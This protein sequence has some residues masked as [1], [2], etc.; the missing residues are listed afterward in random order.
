V[1]DRWREEAL[2][3]IFARFDVRGAELSTAHPQPNE[4]AW[5][6]GHAA[7]RR[8]RDVR[9]VGA[10]GLEPA[11]PTCRIVVPSW[12]AGALQRIA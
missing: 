10:R 12:I 9:M 7:I 11:C 4:N 8:E 2:H 1:P 6:L 5:L 3:E